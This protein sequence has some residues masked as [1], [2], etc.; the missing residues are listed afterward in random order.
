MNCPFN[1]WELEGRAV[2]VLVD[3]EVKYRLDF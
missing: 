1:G 2:C 3:G